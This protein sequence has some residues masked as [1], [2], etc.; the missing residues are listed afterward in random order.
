M[1]IVISNVTEE[2]TLHVCHLS[3]SRVGPSANATIVEMFL[4]PSLLLVRRKPVPPPVNVCQIK[5]SGPG[6]SVMGSLSTKIPAPTRDYWLLAGAGKGKDI[7]LVEKSEERL[8]GKQPLVCTRVR[9]YQ[10]R[11][12]STDC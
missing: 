9:R 7:N 3:I 10:D 11:D 1:A 5:L 6:G 12:L 2:R 4:H 8:V